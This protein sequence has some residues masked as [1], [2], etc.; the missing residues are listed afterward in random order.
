MHCSASH[1]WC[2]HAALLPDTEGCQ[3]R[4][5]ILQSLYA[6]SRSPI[7]SLELNTRS[8]IRQGCSDSWPFKFAIQMSELRLIVNN[9]VYKTIQ[10]SKIVTL[11]IKEKTSQKVILIDLEGNWWLSGNT[12]AFQ[13]ETLGSGIG[14]YRGGSR[15]SSLVLPECKVDRLTLGV[16]VKDEIRSMGNTK[17][18]HYSQVIMSS[19]WNIKAQE[20]LQSRKLSQPPEEM[21]WTC[22]YMVAKECRPTLYQLF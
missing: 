13:L 11:E 1:V 19:I 10:Y 9:L 18:T 7:H 14:W 20:I 16:R 12:F 3:N 5:L 15:N 21:S 8:G 4:L 17:L 22:R 6:S 2:L